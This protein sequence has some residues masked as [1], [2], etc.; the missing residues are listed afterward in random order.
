M[1]KTNLFIKLKNIRGFSLV[2]LMIVVSILSILAAFAVPSYLEQSKRARRAD[3]QSALMGLAQAMERHF[4]ENSTYVSA[5]DAGAPASTIF[6]S[7]A[8]LDGG[9]K[10]YNLEIP[11]VTATT[12]RLRAAPISG[13]SQD[14][15]GFIELLSTGVKQWDRD[16]GGS[17][18]DTEKCWETSC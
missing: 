6:P 3:A 9:A 18:A 17:V 1:M 14:G 4:T 5:V 16:D 13:K 15:D 8:P 10:Y 11:A 2:E 12:Y 7:Q